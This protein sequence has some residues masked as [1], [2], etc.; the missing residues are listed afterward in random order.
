MFWIT[1]ILLNC[2]KEKIPVLKFWTGVRKSTLSFWRKSYGWFP[3]LRL[4]FCEKTSTI[5]HGEFTYEHLSKLK[6]RKLS[7]CFEI[8]APKCVSDHPLWGDH[9]WRHRYDSSTKIFGKETSNAKF[10]TPYARISFTSLCP[11]RGHL[12]KWPN[13]AM[14][15]GMVSLSQSG[16]RQSD[17]LGHCSESA[18]R[19]EL[20][21]IRYI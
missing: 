19:L 16:L 10:H 14:K 4:V 8:I 13:S 2:S 5:G 15:M 17:C 20:Y 7:T 9:R 6:I 21:L 11:S 1:R 3:D 12:P 18:H